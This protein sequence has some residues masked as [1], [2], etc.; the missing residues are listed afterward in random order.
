MTIKILTWNLWAQRYA[1]YPWNERLRIILEK[2]EETKPDILFFQEVEEEMRRDLVDELHLKYHDYHYTPKKDGAD[3]I[4][5]ISQFYIDETSYLPLKGNQVATFAKIEGLMYIAVHLKS[6]KRNSDIRKEQLVAILKEIIDPDKTVILGDFNED[7]GEGSIYK[8]LKGNGFD[9][10]YDREI[11]TTK[12]VDNEG[13][14]VHRKI[15]WI[16]IPTYLKS[17]S[18]PIISIDESITLPDLEKGYPSDHHP[19]CAEFD[20]DLVV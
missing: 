1:K 10:V 15:D 5:I 12:K 16:W 2:I 7:Y 19:I 6:K 20:L 18:R 11:K 9:H 3:G 4:L 13:T 14:A 17:T 8:M